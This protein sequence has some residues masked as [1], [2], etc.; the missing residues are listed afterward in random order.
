MQRFV[1]DTIGGFHIHLLSTSKYK[2]N[3]IVVAFHT[4]LEEFKA[5]QQAL[6][7]HVLMRGSEQHPTAES[8]QL[9]LSELYGA[10]LTGGV[11]KRGERQ[12]VEFLLRVVNEKYLTSGE[13]LFEKGL[14]LLAEMLFR[15][16]LEGGKF[17]QEFVEKEKEQHVKRIDSLFDDKIVYANERCL[18]EMT[19]GERFSIPKLGR[20]SDLDR[21]DAANLYSAYREL[22]RTAPAHVYVVGNLEMDAVKP[23]LQ[24]YL[25]VER[26]PNSALQPTKT[27]VMPQQVKEVIDRLNVTQGK[28][29]IGMR[30]SITQS[31]DLYPALMMYNGILG[32]F[33]HSKLF[34]N[35]R[36]K[37]SLAYYASSRLESYKGLLYIQSGIQIPQYQKTL[38]IIKKQIQDMQD[39]NITDIEIEFTRNGLVN[40]LQTLQDSADGLIDMHTGGVV[41][42]RQRTIEELIEQIRQTGKDDIVNVAQQVRMDTIYFLRDREGV[43]ANA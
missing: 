13:P 38:D 1:S 14:G 34:V 43:T 2:L 35:V 4:D 30:T 40:A 10:T 25:A 21:I 29:N 16:A 15:P 42:G 12:I 23:L 22:I 19:D 27:N 18:E 31:N 8:I 3:T 41:S 5:T 33:P 32:G 11:S 6:I 28:L 20:K 7:P 39:G 36:E 26:Q 37:A 9:S 17:K 24:K